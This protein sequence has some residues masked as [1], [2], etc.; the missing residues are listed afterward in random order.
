MKAA[1]VRPLVQRVV[2]RVLAE[3]G[4]DRAGRAAG[5]SGGGPWVHIELTPAEPLNR[6]APPGV[7]AP[8]LGRGALV[9]S[10]ELKLAG[11]DRT[12]RVAADALVTPAAEDEAFRLGIRIVRGGSDAASPGAARR[13]AIGCDHGGYPLKPLLLEFVRELGWQ[14]VDYGTHS[15]AAC[16]YPDFALAVAQAVAEGRAELGICIDGAGLGSAITANKVPG[17]RAAPCPSAEL[18][19]NAREHNFANVLTLGAKGARAAELREIVR[20]FLGTPTGE[21]RHARRVA[22]IDAIEARYSKLPTLNRGSR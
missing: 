16:D 12:L 17:V 11:P 13:V 5:P 20:A 4:L 21:A 14:A 1:E 3:R 8:G 22:K 18:A 19:R 7:S 15:E 10:A 2:G 6:P 9:T